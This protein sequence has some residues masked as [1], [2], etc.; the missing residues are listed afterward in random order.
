MSHLIAL[1]A[2]V[3]RPQRAIRRFVPR[4][5]AL[6]AAVVIRHPQRARRCDMA[7]LVALE[8]AFIGDQGSVQSALLRAVER[9]V[10][11]LVAFEAALLF[12]AI[13]GTM[14]STVAPKAFIATFR[15]WAVY[16]PMARLEALEATVAGRG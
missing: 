11:W 16:S 3:H 10:P 1:E 9:F 2:A 15:R 13:R 7:D 6:E 4:L 5:I 12:P 8:A 14:A